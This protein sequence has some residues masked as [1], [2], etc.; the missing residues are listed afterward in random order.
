MCGIVGY[1]GHRNCFPILIKGLKRVEYRGYDSVGLALLSRDSFEV[2]KKVGKVNELEGEISNLSSNSCLGIAHT[3]WATHGGIT[4]ENAHP[5]VDCSKGIAIVHNGII[6]NCNELKEELILKG[7]TFLSE[8][9]S[10]IIA[11]ILEEEYKSNKDYIKATLNT[12]SKLKGSFALL[13]VIKDLEL[14]I[15]ARLDS[16]LTIGIGKDEYFVSSDILSFIEY[17]DDVIFL[18]NREVCF[19]KRDSL[20][21]MNFDGSEIKRDI[22]K[23]AKELSDLSNKVFEHYTLKEIH[24]QT[25]VVRLALLQDEKRFKTFLEGIKRAKKIYFT[26]CGTSYHACVLATY[27]LAKF[28]KLTSEALIASEFDSIFELIDKDTLLIAISQS[29][30]TADL[31]SCVREAKAKGAK[32]FALVNNV[33]SSLVREVDLFLPLNCGPEVGVAATKSFIAQLALLYLISLS[34]KGDNSMIKEL[35]NLS[36]SIEEVLKLEEDIK[37]LALK[38]KDSKDFYFIGRALHYP[39]ALE[40]ALKLKELSYI[41]A[42]GLAAGE[43][44]HG[45]LALISDG[46]PTLAI[47]P[48]DETYQRTLNNASEMKARG[49]KII[50]LSDENNSLY[51]DFIKI[52]KVMEVF[53]PIIEVIPL[54]LLA[55]YVTL[56]RKL[57][58]DYPRNLAKSVTVP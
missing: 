9:D 56:Q 26:G 25:Q 17:T 36:N 50:G 39:I 46:T 15:G 23:V 20:T 6:E 30:E 43:L 27:L 44:K 18:N 5:H 37:R 24:E 38:Y 58:P 35:Y 28:P 29:G 8:T 47:N 57:N 45:P 32:V 1:I 12:V 2:F 4:E 51:D 42:E 21:L 49:A 3:R 34:L 33:N 22:V 53:Y 11:H 10:E 13:A 19:I 41:H 14:I 16:P 55:Y 48:S 52:P 7:H 54:Q 40:G 31:L